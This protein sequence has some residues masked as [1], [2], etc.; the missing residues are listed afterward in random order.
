MTGRVARRAATLGVLVAAL[1]LGAVAHAATTPPDP[2]AD[3]QE[4]RRILEQRR[5]REVEPPRPLRRPLRWLAARLR[6]A[7]DALES[8][9][10]GHPLVQALVA[11]GVVA[12]FVAVLAG[13]V[14]RRRS[15]RLL[16]DAERTESLRGVDPAE[17]ERQA[18]AAELAGEL[19]VALRLRFRA[20]L[21]RLAQGRRVTREST[22]PSGELSRRLGSR[23]F[24]ELSRTF[25]EVVYGGRPAVPE[26]VAEARD[27]WPRVL[28]EVGRP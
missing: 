11:V 26:D 10:P 21:T 28:E 22:L 7:G 17:L 19:E 12:A 23:R 6:E 1:L 2:A 16:R 24:D 3:R 8:L 27:G 18:D 25:D 13:P 14:L 20:G 9:V 5:F 15:A 4:A